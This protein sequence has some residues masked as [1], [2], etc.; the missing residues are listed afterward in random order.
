MMP[1]GK[2]KAWIKFDVRQSDLIQ[3]DDGYIDGYIKDSD[4]KPCAVFVRFSDGLIDM[5]PVRGL[6]AEEKETE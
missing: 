3:G 2:T 1:T 5:V 6:M 4:D